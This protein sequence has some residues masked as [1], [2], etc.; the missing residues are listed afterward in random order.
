MAKSSIKYLEIDDLELE[1]LLQK[2]SR[3]SL[4]DDEVGKLRNI[5]E[6]LKYIVM[7]LDKNRVSIKRLKKMLFGE[8]SE[9]LSKLNL[10]NLIKAKDAKDAAAKAPNE[11]SSRDQDSAEN[12][13]KKNKPRHQNLWV[14]LGSGIF[15]S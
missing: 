13:D 6:T 2:A 1:K 12:T 7:E 4:A 14:N 8:Q 9:K 10:E 3:T 5:T 15:P 11:S